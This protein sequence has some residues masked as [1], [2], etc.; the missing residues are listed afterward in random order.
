MAVPSL[1]RVMA[2]PLPIDV[3]V[4][5]AFAHES[6]AH[7][8]YTQHLEAMMLL[9]QLGRTKFANDLFTSQPGNVAIVKGFLQQLCDRRSWWS[10][11]VDGTGPPCSYVRMLSFHSTC[12]SLAPAVVNAVR[13]Q[14][15]VSTCISILLQHHPQASA[16]FLSSLPEPPCVRFSLGLE[17]MAAHQA[18]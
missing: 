18:R 1:L 13:P 9:F 8:G 15:E 5:A 14:M 12:W 10:I 4:W 7:A 17:L 16:W 6:G 11:A 3:K 2:R